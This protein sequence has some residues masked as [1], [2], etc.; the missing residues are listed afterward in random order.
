MNKLLEA[1]K[2]LNLLNISGLTSLTRADIEIFH[3]NLQD[4]PF[5]VEYRNPELRRFKFT[6]C[7]TFHMRWEFNSN[8]MTLKIYEI[9]GEW[10]FTLTEDNPLFSYFLNDQ[11]AKTLWKHAQ[12]TLEAEEAKDKIA[13]VE[14]IFHNFLEGKRA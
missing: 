13:R 3:Q 9:I 1:A 7:P 6:I 12:E 8:E 2:R 10:T 4:C 14:K 5:K 11:I